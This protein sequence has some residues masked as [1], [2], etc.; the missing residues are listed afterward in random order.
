MYDVIIVVLM[1]RHLTKWKVFIV[2]LFLDGL[3]LSDLRGGGGGSEAWMTKLKLPIRKLLLYNS[4]TLQILVLS[5][6]PIQYGLLKKTP[7][8]GGEGI[9]PSPILTSLFLAQPR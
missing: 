9:L 8:Y 7:Q 1:L 2:F 3:T 5:L 6:T 4:Q